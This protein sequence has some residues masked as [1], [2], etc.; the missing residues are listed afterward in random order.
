MSLSS[1]KSVISDILKNQRRWTINRPKLR[2]IADGPLRRAAKHWR[3]FEKWLSLISGFLTG[4][5]VFRNIGSKA[6]FDW[7]VLSTFP[8]ST[9]GFDLPQR[10]NDSLTLKAE[11]ASPELNVYAGRE[12]LF[13]PNQDYL[14]QRGRLKVQDLD[15]DL[16]KF[17]QD[18]ALH[19]SYIRFSRG[20]FC[21][22]DRKPDPIVVPRGI[23][24]QGKFPQNWYHWMVNILPKL[25]L[26]DGCPLVPDSVP[27]LVSQSIK[28]SNFEE[29]L[30]LALASSRKVLY[31][32]DSPHLVEDAYVID[33]PCH[34]IKA[35]RGSR[36][37]NWSNLGYFHHELMSNWRSHLLVL[38]DQSDSAENQK[39][40]L[41]RGK[42]NKRCYNEDEVRAYVESRGY[43]PVD[44]E[45]LSVL[46]Q[47][48]TFARAKVV[49]G[50][51]GAQWTGVMW[52]THAKC[53]FIVPEFLTR[54][55][56]F[57]KL[58]NL[59]GSKFYEFPLLTEAKSWPE[60]YRSD[61][62][63]QVE[64]SDLGLALDWIE[65]L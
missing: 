15:S 21:L 45:D 47:V 31:L 42:S 61:S 46:D 4:R 28:G 35:I 43:L 12:I 54:T 65:S 38:G 7:E 33:S 24:L 2:R 25:K 20:T 3:R 16:A 52:A 14:E 30:L 10:W 6:N 62:I 29:A 1:P 9:S 22:V 39:L 53:L 50:T 41:L 60:Y 63:S 64:T 34:E 55:S 51:T 11:L 56:T 27:I 40:F 17:N 32:S 19:S 49:V 37:P 13:E 44:M 36:Y 5:L 8:P 59:G 26:L 58:A 23:I 57:P 48:K 18:H